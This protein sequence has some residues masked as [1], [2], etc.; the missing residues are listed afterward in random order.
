[1]SRDSNSG[2]LASKGTKR[3]QST[4][5]ALGYEYLLETYLTWNRTHTHT[6][7]YIYT[8]VRKDPMSNASIHSDELNSK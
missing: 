1:M 3:N 4:P 2:T 6:H 8:T 5:S 7:A